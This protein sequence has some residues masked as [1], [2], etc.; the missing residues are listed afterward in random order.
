M[1]SG[2]KLLQR[3][4]SRIIFEMSQASRSRDILQIRLGKEQEASTGLRESPLSFAKVGESF[5]AMVDYNLWPAG[6]PNSHAFFVI[7]HRW[8]ISLAPGNS[9]LSL[10][11]LGLSYFFISLEYMSIQA[12]NWTTIASSSGDYKNKC[13]CCSPSRRRHPTTKLLVWMKSYPH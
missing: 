3:I 9:S 13:S 12:L 4:L 6:P 11:V 2:G 5:K 8:V 10:D 7:V 1:V